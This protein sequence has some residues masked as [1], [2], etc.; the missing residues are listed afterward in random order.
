MYRRKGRTGKVV[1]WVAMCLNAIVAVLA[2]NLDGGRL[3]DERRRLQA[4]ADAAASAGADNLYTHYW[5]YQGADPF[6][7]ASAAVT[8]MAQ[9][10]GIPLNA[11]SVNIPPATGLF[12]GKPGHVEVILHAQIDATFGRLLTSE[13]MKVK[14]RS[15]CRG[16]PLKIGVQLMRPTG[17]DACLNQSPSFTVL[18]GPLVVNSDDPQAFRWQAFGA[19]LASHVDVTGGYTNNNG[20]AFSMRVRTGVRPKPD[21]FAYLPYPETSSLAVCSAS[22][23]T[24]DSALPVVLDPGVY[25]GGVC[26][27][28]VSEVLLKPGIFI[29]EG[30]G[31]SIDSLAKVTGEDVV[32]FNTDGTT[33]AGPIS[34]SSLSR[35]AL[36]PPLAGP[37]QGILLFQHRMLTDPIYLR[38]TGQTDITGVVYALTAPT[39]LTGHAPEGVDVLGG[40]FVV[41]SMNIEGPGGIVIDLKQNPPRVPDLRIVE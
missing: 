28:G 5:T 39:T 30:G 15:V 41:D 10:Q 4:I 17:A 19:F 36:S 35:V 8:S 24:I 34:I 13:P 37:Y 33:E 40:A 23:L 32:I 3:Q 16:E 21:P 26:I 18:N 38:G 20:S 11:I 25:Q 6:G 27:T 29:M 12:A 1:V 7:T 22:P 31:F 9:T 14:A 2:I